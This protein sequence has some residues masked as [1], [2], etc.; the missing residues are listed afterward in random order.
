MLPDMGAPGKQ[1]KTVFHF[2]EIGLKGVV[3]SLM[4]KRKDLMINTLTSASLAL[5]TRQL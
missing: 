2:K 3:V 1:N 4:N 5:H